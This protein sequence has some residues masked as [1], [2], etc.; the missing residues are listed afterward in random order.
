MTSLQVKSVQ[1]D[2]MSMEVEECN[3]APELGRLIH[4]NKGSENISF[5]ASTPSDGEVQTAF[6]IPLDGVEACKHGGTDHT[7]NLGACAPAPLV[8]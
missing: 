7:C 8:P 3:L 6:C 4:I 5:F 1:F 2:R